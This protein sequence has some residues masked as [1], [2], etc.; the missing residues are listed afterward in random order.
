MRMRMKEATISDI[1]DDVGGWLDRR[2]V[3]GAS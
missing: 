1:Y 3:L 2:S